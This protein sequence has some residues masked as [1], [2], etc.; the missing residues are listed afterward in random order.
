MEKI[1]NLIFGL[2]ATL[3]TVNSIIFRILL[4]VLGFLP[5]FVIDI[6]ILAKIIL[7]ICLLILP[8]VNW[9]LNVVLWIWGFIIVI[10]RELSPFSIVYYIL[11]A[12]GAIYVLW[13][14]FAFF[15]S[16]YK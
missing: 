7:G 13:V 3:F 9:V 5:L 12:L 6:P 15:T 11:F 1:K 16:R 8:Y 10:N 2:F 4:F 14:V